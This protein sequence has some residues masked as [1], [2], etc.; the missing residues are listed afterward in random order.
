LV[1][2]VWHLLDAVVGDFDTTCVPHLPWRPRGV[3]LV[4][5]SWAC[6][7]RRAGEAGFGRGVPLASAVTGR[8]LL[9]ATTSLTWVVPGEFND[10]KGAAHVRL[11]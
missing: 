4:D 1:E 10:V 6:G 3:V 5:A 8:V 7:A 11:C 2:D 9:G